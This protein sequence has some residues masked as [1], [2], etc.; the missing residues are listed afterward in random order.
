[1]NKRNWINFHYKK[2]NRTWLN[3]SWASVCFN[4]IIYGFHTAHIY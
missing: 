2:K 1:V 4:K 3:L